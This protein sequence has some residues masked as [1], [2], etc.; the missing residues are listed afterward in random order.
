M[1]EHEGDIV[2]DNGRVRLVFERAQGRLISMGHREL[3]ITLVGEPRLADNWRLLV[4]LPDWRG[5]DVFGR[6]QRLSEV[7]VEGTSAVLTWRGLRSAGADLDIAVTMRVTLDGD[8][9]LFSATVE[10]NSPHVI[11]EVAL[12]AIGGLAN[13]AE[14]DDWTFLRSTW[15]G[16]GDHWPFYAQFPGSYLGPAAPVWQARYADEMAMPWVDLSNGRTRRGVSVGVHDPT[17]RLSMVRLQLFPGATYRGSVQEWPDPA[18][19]GG[20]TPLGVTLSWLHFPFVPPGGHYTGPPVVV[21]FH[22]GIWYA[23]ADHY[24]AWYDRAIGSLDKKGSWLYQ[25]DAWQSTIISYPEDTIGYRFA[26]LPRLAEEAQAA[27]INVLQIDGW[28]VGGIDRAY[29]QYEPD[30]RLG[31]WDDLAVALARCRAMGVYVLLF[32]N[33]QWANLETDWFARELHQYAA[34]DPRGL[35]RNSMGW[36]YHT[37]LGLANQ[38]EWRLVLMDP[39]HPGYR[40]VIV[41]QLLNIVRL[42]APGTQIDKLGG[43][44]G[45]DYNPAAP[46][47]VDERVM[48][49]CLEALAAFAAAA[50]AQDPGFR[51]ASE[52]HWDRALQHVDASYA[53][54][55]SREHIPVMGYTFPEFR[56]SC[57]ITGDFDDGLVNNCLRYGHI[58]NVEARCLHGSAA[59]V[60]HLARYVAEVLRLRRA[61]RS[62]LWES[63]LVETHGIVEIDDPSGEVLAGLHRSLTGDGGALVLNHFSRSTLPVRVDMPEV[64]SRTTTVYRPF[65][66]PEVISLPAQLVVPPNEVVVLAF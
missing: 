49:G 14:R 28:D 29:P 8:D 54:F 5:H 52:T 22:Q 18:Q 9:V 58:I 31:T 30:P 40:R 53:R 10:N 38:C 26:D 48:R 57:C 35:L 64:G 45:V 36:E 27:G 13:H 39:L 7:R 3:D 20:E 42:G 37:A 23:A 16:T 66:L 44:F 56:Q 4:P 46:G 34:R 2:L 17:P 51:I 43:G 47:A 59:D 24:R 61:L 62:R 60:P 50:R 21:H 6:D 41:D 55:F 19:V 25:Q 12:P 1:G 33:L 65:H 32:A 63:R 15:G 11:E